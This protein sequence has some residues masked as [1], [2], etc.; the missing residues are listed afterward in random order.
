M[1][2]FH[3]GREYKL[4]IA[5]ILSVFP[6]GEADYFDKEILILNNL[7]KQIVLENANKL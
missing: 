4:S 5:E 7:D 1:I 6:Q 3:L 2:G